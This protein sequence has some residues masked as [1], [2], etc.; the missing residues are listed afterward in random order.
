[1][2]EFVFKKNFWLLD[3]VASMVFGVVVGYALQLIADS[4]ERLPEQLVL[5]AVIG[6]SSYFLA[7][8]LSLPL[9]GRFR[10][11]P[12]WVWLGVGGSFL[13]ALGK[14]VVIFAIKSWDR[15]LSQTSTEQFVSLLPFMVP[16]TLFIFILVI[17]PLLPL[18]IILRVL[19][20]VLRTTFSS[21]P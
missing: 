16:S 18:L 2:F 11:I 20:Y 8:L 4:G 10:K 21:A 7:Y 19:L 5:A 9:R 17:L 13:F 3:L 14:G 15:S 1:M 12:S 6:G